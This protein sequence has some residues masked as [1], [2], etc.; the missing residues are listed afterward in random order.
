MNTLGL[1]LLLFLL[2]AGATINTS[3]AQTCNA[4]NCQF[5]NVQVLSKLIENLIDIRVNQILS[6]EPRKLFIEFQMHAN[7][8]T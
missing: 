5:N 6:D 3:T 4:C 2:T 8:I 1:P 7:E